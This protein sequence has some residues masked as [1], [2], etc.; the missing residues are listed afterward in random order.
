MLQLHPRVASP[1]VVGDVKL[2]E[3]VLDLTMYLSG[4]SDQELDWLVDYYEKICS[5][6]RF[7]FY[8]IPELPDWDPVADPDLTKSGRAA[9]Q[10]GIRRPYLEPVRNRIR[11]QRE[12][13]LQ[14]WDGLE[15]ASTHFTCGRVEVDEG[16]ASFVRMCFPLDTDL[17]A[18]V[19]IAETLADSV[20]FISGH[21]GLALLYDGW[22]KYDSFTQH[23]ALA[24]RWWGLDLEDLNLTLPWMNTAL[25]GAQWLTLVGH[26]FVN[27]FGLEPEFG[28]F[29]SGVRVQSK[30]KGVVIR[31]GQEPIQGDQHTST[32]GLDAY[33]EVATALQ[34]C[35]VD[36]PD[37]FTGDG[38]MNNG[39]TQGWFHRFFDPSGWR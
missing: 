6:A 29:S 15:Q 28:R 32:P 30:A 18:V 10:S 8:G 4:P 3:T 20:D 19:D 1:L 13:H 11:D 38:F 27:D 9:A 37:E 35:T 25:K 33:I 16:F 2:S 31:A 5:K 7:R 23:Y 17:E 14:I 21:G 22:N 39:N 26:Q 34:H 36:P 12:F 24:R